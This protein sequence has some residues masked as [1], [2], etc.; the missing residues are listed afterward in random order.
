MSDPISSF[1][2]TGWRLLRSDWLRYASLQRIM[3]TIH[4]CARELDLQ[5][6]HLR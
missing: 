6:R 1:E 5:A 4:E 3:K 2:N